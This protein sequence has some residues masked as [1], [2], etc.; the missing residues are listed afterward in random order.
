MTRPMTTRPLKVGELAKQTGLSVRTL[1][2]YDEIGL[3]SPSHRTA[4]GH[5]SY[6]TRDVARLQRI[7][8]LRTLGFSLDQIRECIERPEFSARQVIRLHIEQL[9]ER[10]EEERKLCHRLRSIATTLDSN[11]KITVE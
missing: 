8:S 4:A 3:L 6:T 7:V 5:R 2:Y 9:E 1:R 11:R 10:I